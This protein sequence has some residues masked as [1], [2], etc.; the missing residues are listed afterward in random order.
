MGRV[1]EEEET[2]S[3][4]PFSDSPLTLQINLKS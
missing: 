2:S 4:H 3:L 1:L